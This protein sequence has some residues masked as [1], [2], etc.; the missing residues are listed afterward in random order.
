[1]MNEMSQRVKF[2]FTYIDYLIVIFEN[3]IPTFF[4]NLIL[5]QSKAIFQV[6]ELN[7]SL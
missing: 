5:K 7:V 4:L 2:I 3:Y 6:K 1:M